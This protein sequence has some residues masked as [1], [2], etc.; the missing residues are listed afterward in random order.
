LPRRSRFTISLDE[1]VGFAVTGEAVQ[2]QGEPLRLEAPAH[3]T[4]SESGDHAYL[5]ALERAANDHD[6]SALMVNLR[7]QGR[8][9]RIDR[10]VSTD[11]AG[12][13]PAPGSTTRLWDQD[14]TSRAACGQ[15]RPTYHRNYAL[16]SQ[17]LG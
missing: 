11:R 1:K 2:H 10:D 14:A 7:E 12:W 8:F 17:A 6:R 16:V 4:W 13:L 9:V 3:V 15:S 5:V